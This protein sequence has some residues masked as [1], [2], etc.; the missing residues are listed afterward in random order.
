MSK[1]TFKISSIILGS[2]NTYIIGTPMELELN[3]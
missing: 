1:S 2:K 3:H